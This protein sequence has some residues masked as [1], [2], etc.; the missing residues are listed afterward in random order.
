MNS[1]KVLS[2]NSNC[3]NSY[4]KFLC[5]FNFPKCSLN[6]STSYPI[7]KSICTKFFED[8]STSSDACDIIYA[9]KY[10]GLDPNC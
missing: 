4:A 1:T 9:K 10:P 3:Y 6:P 5:Q 7:C 8:C 2:N